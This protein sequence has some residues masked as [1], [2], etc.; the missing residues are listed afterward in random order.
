MGCARGCKASEAGWNRLQRMALSPAHRWTVFLESPRLA[1]PWARHSRRPVLIR[2]LG[3]L[4]MRVQAPR[5]AQA[6]VVNAGPAAE[7]PGSGPE[8]RARDRVRDAERTRGSAHASRGGGAP[9]HVRVQTNPR[10]RHA[11][12]KRRAVPRRAIPGGGHG[13]VA[14]SMSA[15]RLPRRAVRPVAAP[16]KS[17]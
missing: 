8:S 14:V 17:D 3:D 12:G 6:S 10:T 4:A 16:G 15:R 2:Q 7:R 11:R 1:L 13:P 5:R 9:S